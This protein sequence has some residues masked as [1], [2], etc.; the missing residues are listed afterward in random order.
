MTKK[1]SVLLLSTLAVCALLAGPALVSNAADKKGGADVVLVASSL[2][3]GALSEWRFVDNPASPG[4]KL[5]DTPNSGGNLDPP[6]ESDPHVVS[7]IKV[8]GGVPYRVWVHMKVGTAKGVSK[9]N[10]L[11][12]QFSNVVDAKG[13]GILKP[14][15][16]SYLTAQGPTVSGWVWVPC[17]M[18]GEKATKI[19]FK[20]GGDVTVYIQAGQEGV[21]FD[22]LV[23]SPARFLD[24]APTEAVV[25]TK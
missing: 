24:A 25:S 8:E 17:D 5:V 14:E 22:Q 18:A 16:A 1:N 9:A 15:S 7:K 20:G 21:G 10:K 23:L 13:K 2:P 19:T 3:K 6:P 12:V 4:G 11:W